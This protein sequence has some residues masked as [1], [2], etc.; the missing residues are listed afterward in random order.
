[1][2]GENSTQKILKMDSSFAHRSSTQKQNNMSRKVT[3]ADEHGDK[4]C[5]NNFVDQLHYSSSS[6]SSK[7]IPAIGCHYCVIA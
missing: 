1:M 6:F 3:F 7:E 2:S 4:I 5:E